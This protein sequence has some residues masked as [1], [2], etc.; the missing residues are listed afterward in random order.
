MA[1][2]RY[3]ATLTVRFDDKM[4]YGLYKEPSW[5][6]NARKQ[7]FTDFYVT[8]DLEGRADLISTILY[9]NPSYYWVLIVVNKPIDPMNWPKAG[10]VIKVLQ[11]Q[12][13]LANA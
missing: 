7:D 4:V 8:N 5:I 9:N 2:S 12:L 13:V 3:S 6:T 1:K 10:Q 11:T